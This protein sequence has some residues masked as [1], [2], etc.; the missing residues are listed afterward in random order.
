MSI[1]G[2]ELVIEVLQ[3]LAHS[4][5]TSYLITLNRFVNEFVRE[6]SD[7]LWCHWFRAQRASFHVFVRN[8]DIFQLKDWF[9][10]KSVEMPAHYINQTLK[11]MAEQ[12][13]I[14][15]VPS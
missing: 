10:W 1:E 12:M 9:M 13:G 7:D 4:T 2:S 3:D 14:E 15:K 8:M 5:R 6:I 11:G